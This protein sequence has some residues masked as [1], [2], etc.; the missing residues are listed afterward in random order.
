MVRLGLINV[1]VW[2][3]RWMLPHTRDKR[4]WEE[5]EVGHRQGMRWGRGRA[6]GGAGA[7]QKVGQRRGQ[8][9]AHV[10]ITRVLDKS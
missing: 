4:M 5:G 10:S 3:K 7:G 1:N 9:D 2:V 6:Q 8:G